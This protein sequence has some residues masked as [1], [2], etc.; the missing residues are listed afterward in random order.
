MKLNAVTLM[1]LNHLWGVRYVSW[2]T[3]QVFTDVEEY[4]ISF[5]PS[6]TPIKFPCRWED[7]KQTLL[8][9]ERVS[10]WVGNL[11]TNVDIKKYL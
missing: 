10:L 1:G 3:I 9:S 4:T 7:L 6:Y 5:T 11:Y 2:P 8:D